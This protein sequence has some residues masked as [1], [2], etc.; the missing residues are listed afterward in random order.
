MKA[1]AFWRIVT[2]DHVDFLDR[3][4]AV[5]HETS[6]RFC[7]IGDHAVNAYAEPVVGLELDLVI[8]E[9][10]LTALLSMLCTHFT[11]EGFAHGLTV[12]AP[13][14]GLRV[15]IHTDARYMGFLDGA[16]LATVLG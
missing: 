8:A 10:D 1:R 5:L 7:L 13:G 2:A 11:V 3:F 12:T 6:T 15:Q 14:S 9:H 4:L 16:A